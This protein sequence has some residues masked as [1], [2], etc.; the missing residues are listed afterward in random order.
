MLD[1]DDYVLF[2]DG[3]VEIGVDPSLV[4]GIVSSL[5]SSSIKREYITASTPPRTIH[6]E[7]FAIHKKL[8][9]V[10]KFRRFISETM[11]VTDSE[12]EGWGWVWNNKWIK[13]NGVS[14]K[15]P[16]MT[17]TDNVYNDFA[18]TFPVMQVSWN[19][20]VRYTEWLSGIT[21]K[22][23]RLPF[24]YEWEIFGTY[25]GLNSIS[26]HLFTKK[27]LIYSDIDF[28]MTLQNN[29]QQSEFQLGLLW[30]WTLDWYIG[31]DESISNKD[32]GNIYKILRGG[33]L[34]SESI[35][36]SKEFRFRRCPTARSP[37]YGFR[38]VLDEKNR[39]P[40]S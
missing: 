38:I 16:F 20:A 35:Q 24:E 3:D 22:N 37:Y 1:S 31:Y 23:F 26:E 29:I 14:W 5:G 30:E 25:A 7:Q 11:Y 32:F 9:T 17:E 36:K 21:G 18:E 27:D 12:K 40:V 28:L 10:E 19:D 39:L 4:D 34:L 13:K 6:Y 33:S 2:S 8:L 15:N